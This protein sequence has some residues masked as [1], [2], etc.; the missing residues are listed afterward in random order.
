MTQINRDGSCATCETDCFNCRSTD[1][2][3]RWQPV[4]IDVIGQN[5]NDGGHYDGLTVNRLIECRDL[6]NDI[7]KRMGH[8]D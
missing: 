4:R 8:Y 2:V 1:P 6:I 5:G 3:R 7:L